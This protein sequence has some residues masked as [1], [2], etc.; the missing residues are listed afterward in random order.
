MLWKKELLAGYDEAPTLISIINY[1]Y[2]HISRFEGIKF[3]I[4]YF[5]LAYS[6][7]GK[8]GKNKLLKWETIL[9]KK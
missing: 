4:T 9:L 2:L 1:S 6:S 3:I 5:I 8:L 7:G